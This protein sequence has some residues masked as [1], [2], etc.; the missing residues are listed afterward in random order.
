[1]AD[2]RGALFTVR[3][4]L[5]AAVYPLQQAISSPVRWLDDI[6]DQLASRQ[7]L[8]AENELLREEHKRLETRQLTFSSLEQENMRLRELL[9][10]PVRVAD[11]FLIAELLAVNVAPYSHVVVVNKGLQ[12]GVYVGQPV[13]D[14]QGVV[15][16]VLRVSPFSAEIMLISDPNHGIPVQVNRNGVRTIALGTGHSDRLVMPYLS[17]GADVEVGDLLVTSGLGGVFPAGYPVARVSVVSSQGGVFAKV[18][19]IPTAQLDRI[20]EVLLV[21]SD[22]TA[23]PAA[24]LSPT[25]GVSRTQES[26]ANPKPPAAASAPVL[27]IQSGE[28]GEDE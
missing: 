12:H 26:P 17:G 4:L 10:S 25:P 1:M 19:A 21:W 8:I 27:P 23:T 20:R 18:S 2:Q 5:S 9:Q 14:A 15:G 13:L 28:D 16:Q 11:R 3:S 7:A 6:A 22:V 24:S